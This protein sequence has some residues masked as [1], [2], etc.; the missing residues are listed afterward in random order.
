MAQP[1]HGA[2]GGEAQEGMSGSP[3][4]APGAGNPD[5]LLTR[6]LGTRQLAANIFNYTVGSGIFLLPATAV[7]TL[8]TAAPLA[9]VACA[10]VIGLVVLCFAEAG[11]R[12]SATGGA[13]A[14]VETALGPMAGFVAI[15][16]VATIFVEP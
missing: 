3:L 1:L 5:A 14:Y 9:Y 15:I 8:G 16:F 11:S 10:I 2:P 13:Y 12:V 7:V 4:G 6:A